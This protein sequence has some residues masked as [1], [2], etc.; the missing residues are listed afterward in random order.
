MCP[1]MLN[2]FMNSLSI[3]FI[4]SMC[5][6]KN[7]TAADLSFLICKCPSPLINPTI[8]AN[9]AELFSMLLIL[10]IILNG[11]FMLDIDKGFLLLFIQPSIT[12]LFFILRI[13]EIFRLPK[14]CFFNFIALLYC[15]GVY[16]FFMTL[17]KGSYF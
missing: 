14:P 7:E 3:F 4:S 16:I 6:E 10:L 12:L 17:N 11:L 13:F 1:L 2:N 9:S 8:Y 15:F 5:F